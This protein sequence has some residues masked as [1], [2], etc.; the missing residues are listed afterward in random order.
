MNEKI[1]QQ[2]RMDLFLKLENP[3][4]ASAEEIERVRKLSEIERKWWKNYPA[5]E[6]VDD[7]L[8]DAEKGVLMKIESDEDFKLIMRFENPDLKDWQPY[9]HKDT[10]LLLKK[11][12]EKWRQKMIQNGLSDKIILSITSLIRTAEYQEKLTKRGKL[13]MPNSPHTKGQSF[14]IDGCGYYENNKAINPRQSENYKDFYNPRVHQLLRELLEDM[15]KENCLNY[16]LEYEDTDNQC[17]H[18]TRNPDYHPPFSTKN[19]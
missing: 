19:D 1:S 14:D 8:K 3:A 5:Y 17:F 9:I 4:K 11:V 2:S 7:I 18:I 13:A 15:K 16:I 12:G 6:T 10:A